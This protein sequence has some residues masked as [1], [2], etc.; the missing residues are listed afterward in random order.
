[1]RES[2]N[3]RG[4]IT[5]TAFSLE[6]DSVRGKRAGKKESRRARTGEKMKKRSMKV[7]VHSFDCSL[8]IDLNSGY[9]KAV[10]AADIGWY[11]VEALLTSVVLN[12]RRIYGSCGVTDRYY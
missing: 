9:Y 3:S 5:P 10:T 8:T 12:G 1:M 2:W 6:S 7:Q 4:R 11:Y